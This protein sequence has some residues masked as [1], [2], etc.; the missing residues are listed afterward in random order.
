MRL[1]DESKM[2]GYLLVSQSLHEVIQ[3]KTSGITLGVVI[4]NVWGM[5]LSSMTCSIRYV[6]EYLYN[7]I[8]LCWLLIISSSI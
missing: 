3:L 6:N 4:S 1:S 5:I 7:I 8:I 2:I